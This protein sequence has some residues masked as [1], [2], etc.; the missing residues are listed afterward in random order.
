MKSFS[1]AQHFFTVQCRTESMDNFQANPDV[2]ETHTNNNDIFFSQLQR[3]NS[4][5]LGNHAEK[6]DMFLLTALFK[7]SMLNV[8]LAC[9][10]LIIF[11]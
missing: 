9:S 11:I 2:L 1:A 3:A 10:N 4:D 6:R 7:T 8:K 5:G